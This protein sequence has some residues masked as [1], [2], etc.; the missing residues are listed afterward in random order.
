MKRPCS[1]PCRLSEKYG[2][3]GACATSMTSA[4][5]AIRPKP[6]GDP[7]RN[8]AQQQRHAGADAERRERLLG[9]PR[10]RMRRAEVE[11]RRQGRRRDAEQHGADNQDRAPPALDR[12]RVRDQARREQ[13][14]NDDRE[15]D[16]G[17][18]RY[19][20]A[21]RA[22]RRHGRP[23][24][25]PRG[26]RRVGEQI[27]DDRLQPTEHVAEPERHRG[28]EEQPDRPENEQREAAG[29]ARDEP[30]VA[31][32]LPLLDAAAPVERGAD[33]DPGRGAEHVEDEVDVRRDPVRQIVLQHFHR[34]RQRA[35]ADQRERRRHAGTAPAADQR[36]EQQEAER[37]VT[38]QVRD[39]VE[40]RPPVPPAAQEEVE[41]PDAGHAPADEGIQARVDDQRAVEPRQRYRGAAVAR[42]RVRPAERGPQNGL[43]V[44]RTTIAVKSRI[45]VSLKTRNHRSLRVLANSSNLRS[46]ERQAWW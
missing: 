19:G 36:K 26:G 32:L 24:F 12:D 31:H 43:T 39:H 45:E 21:A 18:Q 17:R 7:A 30:A 11:R 1:Q 2:S 38:E 27:D 29:T 5:N 46:S 20:R 10:E 8:E 9:H 35:P 3:A 4:V 14:E 42:H 37:Q 41:R 33:R 44:T 28:R 6:G 34:Q 22:R 23:A 16:G 25:G 13:P 40:P 15:L